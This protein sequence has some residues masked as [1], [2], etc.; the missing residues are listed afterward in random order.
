MNSHRTDVNPYAAPAT[1]DLLPTE[2]KA[3]LEQACRYLRGMGWGTITYV[4]F[5]FSFGVFTVFFNPRV[6]LIHT[7]LVCF[8]L[9]LVLHTGVLMLRVARALP[10]R[11]NETY[12]RARWLAIL[13]GAVFFPVFTLPAYI[14]ISRLESYRRCVETGS[15][16]SIQH[17]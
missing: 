1:S 12:K 15:D 5:G 3:G 7:G 11:F 6:V 4:V 2:A 10:S 14:A 13:A 8:L 9:I 17:D 16:H